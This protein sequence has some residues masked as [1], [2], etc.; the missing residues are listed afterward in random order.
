[1]DR[2]SEQ[3]TK[4]GQKV[5]QL[6][7]EE[8]LPNITVGIWELR[9]NIELTDMDPDRYTGPGGHLWQLILIDTKSGQQVGSIGFTDEEIQSFEAESKEVTEDRIRNSVK[10][11]AKR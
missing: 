5:E 6:F 9:D 1:M 3:R 11:I 10:R 7:T 2:V 4:L 8:G